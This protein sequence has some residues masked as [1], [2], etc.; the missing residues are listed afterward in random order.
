MPA[1]GG[2]ETMD[3]R[4]ALASTLD[5]WRDAGVD[6]LVED[7]PRDWLARPEAK[8]AARAAEPAVASAPA[9][10][11][12]DTLEAFLEWRMGDAAPERGWLSPLVPPAGPAGKLM[13]LT[14]MPEAGDENGGVL[15][16][17]APGRLLDRM[18]AAIGESRDS[19]YLASIALARPVTG[20]IPPEQ[21]ARLAT[22]A[23]HHIAL[24]APAK[25]LVL[26]QA[27]KRVLDTTSGSADGN[28]I[29]GINLLSGPLEIVASYSP[30][31]LMERPARK[32]QAWKDLLQLSRG[33]SQ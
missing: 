28:S 5:W 10:V 23:L 11:L 4:G 2:A 21:E 18:L 7:E 14:D 1:M 9:E 15:L 6:T 26:G 17:G 13:I 8:A 16:G 32:A 20:Q 29:W 25:L 24:V 33:T 12:P 22:L 30:R 27:A 19:V 3:A 31:F